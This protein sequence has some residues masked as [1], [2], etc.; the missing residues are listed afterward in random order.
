MEDDECG[1][2]GA[3]EGCS[4]EITEGRISSQILYDT[5]ELL[6]NDDADLAMASLAVA[7]VAL[8]AENGKSGASI[9]EL[10]QETIDSLGENKKATEKNDN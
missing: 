5:A 10:V 6:A 3:C 7:L 8:A 9:L 2:C 1:G 4:E